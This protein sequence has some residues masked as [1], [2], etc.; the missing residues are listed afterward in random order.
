MKQF[1][2]LFA[3]LDATTKTNEKIAAL[4][5][6]FTTAPAED[7]AWAIYFLSGRKLRQLVPSKLLREWAAE[8]AGVPTWLF[9]ESYSVVGDLAETI[10]LIVPPGTVDGEQS[11]AHWVDRRL[12][13]LRKLSPEDQHNAV[14]EIWRQ[15]SP[16]MRF[17]AMKLITGAFRVGVSKGLV[18]R[19]IA[20]SSGIE[21]ETVAHRL[22]GNWEPSETFF[23]SVIQ[24]GNDDARAS[25]PY[26]FCLAHPIEQA[27]S[28]DRDGGPSQAAEIVSMVGPRSEFA[29]EWKW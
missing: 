10:S 19:G 18:T 3:R 25:R 9:E 15:T 23:Q 13:P 2:D 4:A 5:E 12:M 28:P 7:S 1:A 11:L 22:M 14:R 21:A 29:A 6:F 17:V 16:E 20:K 26:P 27:T 24:P 8:E